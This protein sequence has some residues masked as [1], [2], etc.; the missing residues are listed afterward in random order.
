M[1]YIYTYIYLLHIYIYISCLRVYARQQNMTCS[2]DSAL[3]EWGPQ[4]HLCFGEPVAR[5]SSR[6]I[7]SVP[8]RADS[9]QK[10]KA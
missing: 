8:D 1:Y 5:R 4:P 7:T 6:H 10:Q 9:Q 2:P 3:G